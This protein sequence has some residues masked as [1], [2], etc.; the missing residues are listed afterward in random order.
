[1]RSR[2]IKPGFFK[3]EALAEIDPPWGRL[4]FM[5]LWG[6]AD[7]EGRL[8]DRPGHIAVEVFPYDLATARLSIAQVEEMLGKLS[9]EASDPFILRYEKDGKKIIQIINFQKHQSP[10]NTEKASELPP[11]QKIKR[12]KRSPKITVG[13]RK[14]N[15]G[16]TVNSRK[17]FGEN[18]PDSLNPD[19]LITDNLDPDSLNPDNIDPGNIENPHTPFEEPPPP[20]QPSADAPPP[21]ESSDLQTQALIP[22]VLIPEIL[23]DTS[24]FSVQELAILWNE[25]APPELAR[26]NLPFQRQPRQMRKFQD[27][28]KRN[29]KKEWWQ[30]VI[31]AIHNSP[32]LIGA[33]KNRWKAHFD[34]MVLNAE[35]ILDGKYEQGSGPEL[36][37]LMA[38]RQYA[39][40]RKR[41]I[42]DG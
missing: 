36:R 3:N 34:F 25:T 37:S 22:T 41:G 24:P 12:R 18:P 16:D 35:E 6:L 32:F 31:H 5:G 23:T 38:L 28:L 11:Y 15:G 40:H 20:R 7:R 27:A 33:N 1:M 10:H 19:S 13:S 8:I 2:N 21:G 9:K 4:L 26:V 29:K 30:K 39:Q 17:D 14:V 42:S